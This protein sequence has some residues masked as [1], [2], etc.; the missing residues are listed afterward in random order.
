MNFRPLI[1]CA[2]AA[3]GPFINAANLA[4]QQPNIIVIMTDDQGY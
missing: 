3:V 1:A 4:G 2:L